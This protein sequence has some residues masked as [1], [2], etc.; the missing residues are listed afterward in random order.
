[1]PRLRVTRNS[2]TGAA[3]GGAAAAPSV[4]W[5]P[6]EITKTV[7]LDAADAA[8]ITLN[9]S[10][11]SQ[12]N[13]KSGNSYH[14]AQPTASQQPTYAASGLN[15]K[16]LITFDGSNDYL[17]NATQPPAGTSYTSFIAVFKYISG[18]SSEDVPFA[19]GQAGGYQRARGLY[20]AANGTTQGYVGWGAELTSSSLSCDIAGNHH[21]WS[22]VQDSLTAPH[23]SLWRDGSID[24]GSPRTLS[25]NL[26]TT[27]PGFCVGEL[28]Q[29]WVYGYNYASNISV[30]EILVFSSAVSTDN[31]QKCE[32]YL[33][34]KW[35]L[36]ASLPSDHPYK[37]AA[38][39]V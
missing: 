37:S 35:G 28:R 25:G 32:G 18:G 9:G 29:A 10:T 36:T 27:D 31:R 11:V 13:D 21:V 39:T 20:R 30:A 1:M 2:A 24:S 34:H 26:Q 6:A 17:V 14:V 38:P 16:G 22:V 33:A 5:T 12:W 3:A 23:L 15:S 7:W 4:P 19:L 8:T